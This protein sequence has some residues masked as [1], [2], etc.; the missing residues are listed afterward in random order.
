VKEYLSWTLTMIA[1]PVR[2]RKDWV[3]LILEGLHKFGKNGEGKYLANM[4]ADKRVWECLGFSTNAHYILLKGRE[5]DM[6]ETMSDDWNSPTLL[7]KHKELP[8]FVIAGPEVKLSGKKHKENVYT[9]A[10]ESLSWAK[11]MKASSPERR[12]EWIGTIWDSFKSYRDKSS[13]KENYLS[14][15]LQ[16]KSTWDIKGFS[17]NLQYVRLEHEEDSMLRFVFVHPWGTPALIL[18]HTRLPMIVIAGAGIRW[19]DTILREIKENETIIDHNVE[20]AT[21]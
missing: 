20:G 15:A 17:V 1:T 13:S 3:R 8:L 12:K 11:T 4:L 6:K 19:N 2:K 18:E 21:G 16:D 9:N 7:F 10:R 14:D 5:E